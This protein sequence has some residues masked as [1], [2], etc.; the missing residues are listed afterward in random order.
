VAPLAAV[1]LCLAGLG[2]VSADTGSGSGLRAT[3]IRNAA[4]DAGFDSLAR[5]KV[6]TPSNLSQ[7]V[8]NTPEG[9][10]A[11]RQLGKALFW[12]MQVG[13]DGQACA[14]C[15]FHAGAD[16]R[17]KNQLNPGRNGTDSLFGNPGDGVTAPTA[18]LQFG[19]NY[20]LE[21]CDFP[22]HRIDPNSPPDFSRRTVLADTNDVA[23]SQGVF[24]ETFTAII[25]GSPTDAGIPKVDLVFN[26]DGTN[27]RRVEPRQAPSV[28]NAVF[29]VDNF[30]D[31]RAKSSFNGSSPFG[32]LDPVAGVFVENPAGTALVRRKVSIDHASLASQ[33]LAPPVSP[34]EM[35]FD[36]RTSPQLGQK[37]LSLRP[38]G[39]QLVSPEDSTL[40]ALSRAALWDG[41]LVG[42]PGLNTSYAALVRRAFRPRWWASTK[43]T[44][45]FT[46][47]EANFSFFFGLAIQLYESLLV[48]GRSPFDRFM[49]GDDLALTEDQLRGL[50][51]FIKT[52]FSRG[53]L[54]GSVGMGGCVFCHSGPEL[55]GAAY[56][57]TDKKHRILTAWTTKLVDGKLVENHADHA[58]S[59]FFEQGFVNIGVRPTREDPGRGGVIDVRRDENGGLMQRPLSFTRA[60]VTA[61]PSA[62]ALPRCGGV[63]QHPCPV[64][65][66]D[67]VEGA[68]KVPG[69]RNVG[70]TAPYFHNG[71]QA[72][73]Q[74]VVD[75][76]RR[77]GDFGDVNLADVSPFMS[78]VRFDVADGRRIVDFLLGLTDDRVR[79]EQAPFDHPQL[80]VPNGNSHDSR[81]PPRP[82][83]PP[84]PPRVAAGLAEVEAARES[85]WRSRPERA[86]PARSA[87]E[88][89]ELVEI[90][91][92]GGGGR[93]A[94]GLPP[95]GHFLGLDPR[96]NESGTAA[97]R[98]VPR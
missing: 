55:T 38:L 83:S 13:S 12:D 88:I 7:F 31:G 72:T 70:L 45:G 69:L 25:P 65:N 60:A 43:K 42:L 97:S 58:P 32:P 76:Y 94:V 14:S 93:P 86:C 24:Y 20:V 37:M 51:V 92:T 40:G 8:R 87:D 56:T 82:P 49:E 5:V 10:A 54:F 27:V 57:S 52:P 22:F 80:F 29:N 68:F 98:A 39:L 67:L 84:S 19:P 74:Q 33:A 89:T 15:H 85:W 21:A 46:Q 18:H 48:S 11:A 47:M 50:L 90:P 96:W 77:G 59:A 30:W 73:L 16:N 36:G 2:T 41:A 61:L 91:A 71:G 62:P 23:S 26:V 6:P 9:I 3:S 17:T 63:R 78:A 1:G 95:L 34:V 28:I 66:R 79:Q 35:S 4:R 64:G 81:L 44:D 75:F 53:E